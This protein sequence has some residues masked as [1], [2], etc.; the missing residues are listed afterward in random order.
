[1]QS[2]LTYYLQKA[3]KRCHTDIGIFPLPP[4]QLLRIYTTLGKFL[5]CNINIFIVVILIT[6]HYKPNCITYNHI[7]YIHEPPR[8]PS[9]TFGYRVFSFAQV[10]VMF[11]VDS[12]FGF[13]KCSFHFDECDG[14]N[15]LLLCCIWPYGEGFEV[16]W[17]R[18][19]N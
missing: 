3:C 5:T 11:I 17:N 8:N 4:I 1:M 6:Q 9:E 12:I 13:V 10:I 7:W 2:K 18:S 16:H 19:Y 15:I 14:L